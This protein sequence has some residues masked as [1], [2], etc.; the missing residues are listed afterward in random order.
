MRRLLLALML[1]LAVG[2]STAQG[3]PAND[4][5]RTVYPGDEVCD[6]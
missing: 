2:C 4:S 1:V 6:N 5:C 3:T